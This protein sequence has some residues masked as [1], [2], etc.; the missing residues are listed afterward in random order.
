M[1]NFETDFLPSTLEF[2]V[3]VGGLYEL[4]KY[5]NLQHIYSTIYT[6]YYLLIFLLLSLLIFSYKFFSCIVLKL[7]DSCSIKQN[8]SNSKMTK[9]VDTSFVNQISIKTNNLYKILDNINHII[10]NFKVKTLITEETGL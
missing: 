1:S 2:F 9:S 5:L 3:Q 8:E 4:S 6:T 7:N 10:Q